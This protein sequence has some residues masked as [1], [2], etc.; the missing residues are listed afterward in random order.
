MPESG[1]PAPDPLLLAFKSCNNWC[2][3]KAGFRMLAGAEPEDDD[4]LSEEG[5]QNL[6]NYISWQNY[7][8]RQSQQ[9]EIMKLFGG[10]DGNISVP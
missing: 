8:Q 3:K 10:N 6:A 1:H 7:Q 5:R 2:R 9:D 4:D